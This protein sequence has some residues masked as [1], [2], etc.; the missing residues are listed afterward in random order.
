M[1]PIL[2]IPVELAGDETAAAVAEPDID[3]LIDGVVDKAAV[4]G[5]D[6]PLMDDIDVK[7]RACNGVPSTEYPDIA[8]WQRYLI[9]PP[10]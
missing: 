5:I 9:C 2:P 4:I 10:P 1:L 7:R 8:S 3:M 6:I